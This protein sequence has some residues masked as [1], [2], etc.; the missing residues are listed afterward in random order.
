MIEWTQPHLEQT[1]EV[2]SIRMNETLLTSYPA[3]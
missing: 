3:E 1:K 2:W